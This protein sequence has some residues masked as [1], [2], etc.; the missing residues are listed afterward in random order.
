MLARI[1]VAAGLLTLASQGWNASGGDDVTQGFAGRWSTTFGEME[2]RVVDERLEGAYTMEGQRCPIAGRIVD[3][4]FEFEYQEPSVSGVGWFELA[5][6]GSSFAGE[7]REEG[8]TEWSPWTGQRLAV[9]PAVPELQSVDDTTVVGFSG[10]W[11]T[12]YGRLRL[13]ERGGYLHGIFADARDMHDYFS[14][15]VAESRQLQWSPQE[16]LAGYHL[17]LE[18]SA[19]GR[20]LTGQRWYRDDN[21]PDPWSASRLT[22]Q[23]DKRWLIVLEARWESHLEEHEYTFGKMLDAYF[24]RT[25]HVEVRHRVFND[26]A[27]FERY[28]FEIAFLAEPTV[29][30]VATHGSTDGVTVCDDLLGPDFMADV[31]RFA[32]SVELV[33]Y[34][35][36]LIMA[37]TIAE[38]M[39]RS[40]RT[41]AQF[42]ISGYG[43]S[44]DWAGS[45]VIEFMYLDLIFSRG[46]SPAEANAATIAMMPFAGVG[47][48]S[49]VGEADLRIALPPTFDSHEPPVTP[50]ANLALSFDGRDDY[51]EIPGLT[52]DGSTPITLEAWICIHPDTNPRA[53]G[54][55][56]SLA[57]PVDLSIRTT[58]TSDWTARCGIV[59]ATGSQAR[60]HSS[61]RLGDMRGKLTHVAAVWDGRL[62][63]F[64]VNGQP[65]D[66]AP[67][68]FPAEWSGADAAVL[69]IG[70]ASRPDS[71]GTT[72][73]FN[74]M[75]DEVRIS[76]NAR[77]YSESGEPVAFDP[78]PHMEVDDHTLG[79]YHFDEAAGSAVLDASPHARN[80]EMHG[81][82]RVPSLLAP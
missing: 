27:D 30:C 53:S 12:P 73:H 5:D 38:Q 13:I 2:L 9:R 47:H 44:V 22:L 82:E 68:Q 60:I 64:F 41:F 61:V 69:L 14:I 3:G 56:L 58:A 71:S 36:C 17:S 37:G 70:A 67:E 76:S 25:P 34:S 74:G 15:P 45:A 28:G 19:D 4:R 75:I 48:A 20:T 24:D 72:I 7:W 42:A 10:L 23:R 31:F 54:T 81:T 39:H 50:G 63:T 18:L 78:Q 21:R 57:G 77:Y 55:P 8:A 1:A 33:H 43:S 35:S 40:L 6:D 59:T 62:F 29:V 51:V 16:G 49:P 52:I 11:E 32:D 80:G 79:L 26:A 65:T 46:M 66:A